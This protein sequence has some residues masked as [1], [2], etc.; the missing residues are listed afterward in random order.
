MNSETR[1]WVLA[2]RAAVHSI[3]RQQGWD[4]DTFAAKPSTRADA[5]LY[6]QSNVP[7]PLDLD[8]DTADGILTDA[9]YARIGALMDSAS[10][11][12]ARLPPNDI[13]LRFIELN[14]E[15][16]YVG[17][18]SRMD[19]LYRAVRA[20]A[21]RYSLGRPP[22]VEELENVVRALGYEISWTEHP[23]DGFLRVIHGMQFTPGE[24]A[25]ARTYTQAA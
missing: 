17:R 5:V 24:W 19:A 3:A 14:T 11:I 9:A 8:V 1:K 25:G 22:T 7:L 4:G 21:K 6:V 13:A 2:A 18:W 23:R 10:A 16:V 15:R 12:P 20:Y